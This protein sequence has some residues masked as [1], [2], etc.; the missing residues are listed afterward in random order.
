MICKFNIFKIRKVQRTEPKFTFPSEFHVSPGDGDVSPRVN[1]LMLLEVAGLAEA[2][3][4]LRALVWPLASV[5]SLVFL[6]VS[7]V[8]EAPAAVRARVR[9]LARV[10]ALMNA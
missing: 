5:H 4:A 6:Q 10:A 1:H 2:L 9:L 3:A 8:A 7:A